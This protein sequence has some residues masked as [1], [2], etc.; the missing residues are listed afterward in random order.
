M[1]IAMLAPFEE[2]VPPKKY[3][4]TELVI[5]N[6]ITELVK[7]GHDV[8]LFGTGDAEV[9]CR[10][11]AIFPA[12]IRTLPPFDTDQKAR[13][14]VK[15]VG[16]G[17]VLRKLANEPFD[18]IHNHNGWR[19][20]SVSSCVRRP[21]VTT[22]HGPMDQVYQQ[23]VF[24]SSPDFAFISISDN[25]RV[26]YPTLQYVQTVYNG[27]DV[28]KFPFSEKAGGYLCLLGRFSPEKGVKE[29]IKIARMTGM[30]LKIAA[31]IDFV[32]RQFYESVKP[33]I[34][35]RQIQFVGEI[36]F[37]EKT[38]LLKN[39]YA[40]LAPIQWEEPFGLNVIESMACGTPVVGTKRGSFPELIEQGKTGFLGTTAEELASFVSHIPMIKRLDCRKAV[41][42]RFTS[43]IMAEGYLQAYQRVLEKFGTGKNSV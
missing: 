37:E 14:A 23:V 1:R 18:I 31:K 3:G 2:P 9:P 4:G 6:L 40:L 8:T 24:S 42:E 32:D 15:W 27:I 36:S 39:A 29:A 34:D 11:E 22:L 35:G 13:E 41:E 19:F 25:Q 10:L 26:A 33:E 30:P 5:Y 16:I 17:N 28:S 20:L 43:T 38:D 7:M 21:I 12:S